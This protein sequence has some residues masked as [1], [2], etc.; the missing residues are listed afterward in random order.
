MGKQHTEADES[1]QKV[2][3][4]PDIYEVSGLQPGSLCVLACDG[5]WDVMTGQEVAEMVR[6]ALSK[7]AD[8][9]LGNIAASI[10]RTS[11][12]KG[13]RDNVTAMVVQMS[14][15]PEGTKD[16]PDEMKHFEKLTAEDTQDD[17]RQQYKA[18]LR[19]AGFPPQPCACEI[20]GRWF[21]DMHQCPC[22]KVNYCTRDCQKEDWKTHKTVCS[23]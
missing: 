15:S 16:P 23:A 13:S 3:C 14:P 22:K 2:S 6:E 21:L 4:I 10:V 1:V 7:D 11:L 17:T 20:C 9:D 5:V 18:F 19:N 12:D 8:A